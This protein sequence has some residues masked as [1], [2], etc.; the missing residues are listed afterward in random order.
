MIIAL[1]DEKNLNTE[2]INKIAISA[3][4]ISQLSK[5]FQSTNYPPKKSKE[6]EEK[7]IKNRRKGGRE[8]QGKKTAC[9]NYEEVELF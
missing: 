8:S 4:K 1:S 3:N 9:L 2:T 5:D 6:E 7:G